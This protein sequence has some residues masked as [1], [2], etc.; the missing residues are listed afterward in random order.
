VTEDVIPPEEDFPFRTVESGLKASS[1][2]RSQ[3]TSP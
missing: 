2:P 3:P 1:S